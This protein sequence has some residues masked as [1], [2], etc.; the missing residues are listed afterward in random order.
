MPGSP[1]AHNRRPREARIA[2]ELLLR[3]LDQAYVRKSWHGAN[4]RGAVRG[5]APVDAD[6]RPGPGRKSIADHVVHAAYWKYVVRRRLR[7][8]KRGTFPLPGSN[9]F[10][11]ESPLSA[12]TWKSCIA[13]LDAQHRELRAAV[14]QLTDAQLDF[15]R[16]GR[17]TNV[18]L[19]TGIAAHDLYHTGQIQLLKRLRRDAETAPAGRTR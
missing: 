8:E 5:L 1:R 7:G 4:L 13:L 12:E 19:I 10:V 9:W 3:T 15:S 16:T 11:L 14:D 2:V 17:V 18:L 6:W